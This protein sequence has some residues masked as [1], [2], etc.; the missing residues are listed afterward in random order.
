MHSFSDPD[1]VVLT[2]GP[3]VKLGEEGTVI[4]F[5]LQVKVEVIKLHAC[6]QLL[7]KFTPS[8]AADR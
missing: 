3:S 7:A 5:G 6:L 8:V 1:A 2:E 4:E